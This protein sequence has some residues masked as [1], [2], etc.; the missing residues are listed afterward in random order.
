MELSRRESSVLCGVV[1]LY[2]RTGSPVA[3]RQV[4]SSCGQ[5]VS[6]ATI[7]NVMAKLE[8]EGY[9]TRGHASAGCVPTDTGFR[10]FVDS[11][12]P[13]PRLPGAIRRQ[14][15][16]RIDAMKR[17]LF[18]DI[19]WV[20]RV[21]A[22]STREAGVA[23]RPMDDGPV[24]E[25]VSVVRLGGRRAL[26]LVVTT[27]GAVEKRVV[28]F[29]EPPTTEELQ[30]ESNYLNHLYSGMP[31]EHI[32]EHLARQREENGCSDPLSLESRAAG[33]AQQLF[34]DTVGDFEVEVV[35][36][37]KL[38]HSEDFAEAERI[39]SLVST[40]QD[41]RRIVKEW[42]RA[43]D[44]GKTQVLIGRESEVTASGN[45]GMV[46]TLFYRKGRRAGA[47][48][49]VGPRRMDYGRIVPL[50]EFMG[51]TL[52]QMLDGPGAPHA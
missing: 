45:L 5:G 39:R 52:T 8:K 43:F 27:D 9:L 28:N 13:L 36:T 24:L 17:E 19:A 32:R 26:G 38:L 3:S 47:V 20:A 42:R 7:R 18:E 22:E 41:R 15:E 21:A 10:R 4:V 33:V 31:I 51:D 2:I 12:S 23:M 37:S 35:G 48:G 30:H 14:L 49:V 50:V 44:L 1:D 6:A 29:E 25:A 40:L 11:L 46:A 16:E 34:D